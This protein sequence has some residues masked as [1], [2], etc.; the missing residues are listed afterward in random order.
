VNFSKFKEELTKIGEI[1]MWVW[2]EAE[3]VKSKY[4]EKDLVRRR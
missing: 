2:S 1:I 4:G 3:K